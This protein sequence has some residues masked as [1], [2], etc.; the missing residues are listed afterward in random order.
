MGRGAFST[1]SVL[2][3]RALLPF[4]SPYHPN[5]FPLPSVSPRG[6][7]DASSTKEEKE[8]GSPAS[9]F[10]LPPPTTSWEG[11]RLWYSFSLWRCPFSP[12]RYTCRYL[13][14]PATITTTSTS[15]SSTTATSFS[16]PPARLSS[17]STSTSG[18][19]WSH[20]I[21]RNP[22][23]EKEE[24][25][26]NDQNE[27]ES[28]S[29]GVS[30]W[31]EYPE[32]DVPHRVATP[33]SSL[34]PLSTCAI[35]PHTPFHRSRRHPAS[36][37]GKRRESEEV[38]YAKKKGHRTS[39]SSSSSSFHR[40][41]YRHPRAWN[42]T[43]VEEEERTKIAPLRL[44]LGYGLQIGEEETNVL[45][46]NSIKNEYT[47]GGDKK[48][49]KRSVPEK[50]MEHRK[51]KEEVQPLP[52]EPPCSSSR[53]E[54]ISIEEEHHIPP[55]S[56]K[57]RPGFSSLGSSSSVL[58]SEIP[59]P[60]VEGTIP[61][62]QNGDAIE[63]KHA[64]SEEEETVSATS[65]SSTPV[66]T[67]EAAANQGKE[68]TAANTL[69]SNT[70][71]KMEHPAAAAVAAVEEEKEPS[72]GVSRG[73]KAHNGEDI[74][75][76]CSSFSLVPPSLP[77]HAL[78]L[79]PP[80]QNEIASIQEEQWFASTGVPLAVLQ[81]TFC[82][83]ETF[84]QDITALLLSAPDFSAPAAKDPKKD[85]KRGG[86]S[87]HENTQPQQVQAL[88]SKEGRAPWRGSPASSGAALTVV[89]QA[90]IDAW[91]QVGEVWSPLST[92]SSSS[93]SSARACSSR[94]VS[95]EVKEE[96]AFF[97]TKA[98]PPA[99]PFLRAACG[100]A[101][102]EHKKVDP[103]VP[104]G[105]SSS[106][107][108]SLARD[109][110][111][112]SSLSRAPPR[113][114]IALEQGWVP[115]TIWQPLATATRSVLSLL[116]H[117]S[118]R[119]EGHRY[120]SL[121]PP[122]LV[123][124][125]TSLLRTHLEAP[126]RLSPRAPHTMRSN[127]PGGTNGAEKRGTHVAGIVDPPEE[128]E[129]GVRSSSSLSAAR[130]PHALPPSVLVK[131]WRRA[132]GKRL[133]VLHDLLPPALL[134]WSIRQLQL[135][136]ETSGWGGCG[137]VVVEDDKDALRLFTETDASIV[138]AS[139]LSL[140]PLRAPSPPSFVESTMDLHSHEWRKQK[141]VVV[142]LSD[143]LL[144]PMVK[145]LLDPLYLQRHA[146]WGDHLL[147]ST[148]VHSWRMKGMSP[149][150][151]PPPPHEEAPPP[152]NNY[153]ALYCRPVRRGEGKGE[154][155]H[156]ASS[157]A[158]LHRYGYIT[159]SLLEDVAGHA[160]VSNS[161]ASRTTTTTS[162]KRNPTGATQEKEGRP[163][164]DRLATA[165]LPK[166]T[167]SEE[168]LERHR[169]DGTSAPLVA[170]SFALLSP[171]PESPPWWWWSSSSSSSSSVTWIHPLTACH[172]AAV[173]GRQAPPGHF[174]YHQCFHVLLLPLVSNVLQ[175]AALLV[176]QASLM[177]TIQEVE[178][179][180][181]DTRE[182]P[183]RPTVSSG[184]A[185]S[186]STAT[187]T[188]SVYSTVPTTQEESSLPSSTL[189]PSLISLFSTSLL[190]DLLRGC[191]RY[192]VTDSVTLHALQTLLLHFLLSRR[193][194]HLSTAMELLSVM[195]PP[196]SSTSPFTG[197]DA[198]RSST[199]PRRQS[200]ATHPSSTHLAASSSSSSSWWNGE[201]VA[202]F[203]P[204]RQCLC[205]RLAEW[206]AVQMASLLLLS[207][208]SSTPMSATRNGEEENALARGSQ[209]NEHRVSFS[210]PLLPNW[211]ST[212][213]GV[214]SVD[215]S[216]SSATASAAAA[217]SL[218][219]SMSWKTVMEVVLGLL[220]LWP[221][222]A[223]ASPASSSSSSVLEKEREGEA[224][225][226]ES[227]QTWEIGFHTSLTLL[228][229][230][231]VRQT[232]M[233][234]RK[235]EEEEEKEKDIHEE[236]KL[237][238]ETNS[239]TTAGCS[240]TWSTARGSV[241]ASFSSSSVRKS[242]GGSGHAAD[243]TTTTTTA[244]E[245]GVQ[246]SSPC[247]PPLLAME[248]FTI[249]D[250]TRLLQAL[251]ACTASR[252]FGSV[253]TVPLSP[254]PPYH[255]FFSFLLFE[256]LRVLVPSSSPPPAGAA[257]VDP[258]GYRKKREKEDTVTK[259]SEE[260]EEASEEFPM[261]IKEGLST[262]RTEND[263]TTSAPSS[264]PKR[265][266]KQPINPGVREC[267]RVLRTDP[268]VAGVVL[269]TALRM[270]EWWGV[271]KTPFS[272]SSFFSGGVSGFQKN[273]EHHTST[274]EEEEWYAE[275]IT[276]LF[277]YHET[278]LSPRA[279]VASLSLLGNLPV[280]HESSCGVS[281]ALLRFSALPS[282]A[283]GFRMASCRSVLAN[284]S[285]PPT[286]SRLSSLP[287]AVVSSF[288]SHL[289]R[290]AGVVPP[291]TL[292][293]AVVS[294]AKSQQAILK[295]AA[296]HV[297]AM[298]AT[299]TPFPS[300]EPWNGLHSVSGLSIS[301]LDT[302]SLHH[303][304]TRFHAKDVTA[305]LSLS[306][307]A[308]LL[309]A[310]GYL[311]GTSQEV[312]SV[313]HAA[314]WM[315]VSHEPRRGTKKKESLH[316]AGVDGANSTSALLTVPQK[317][318][319]E[320]VVN[321]SSSASAMTAWCGSLCSMATT[322]SA[323][324]RENALAIRAIVRRVGHLLRHV[325]QG[326]ELLARG[327][328]RLM[329]TP[330][331]SVSSTSFSSSLPAYT[332]KEEYGLSSWYRYRHEQQRWAHLLSTIPRLVTGLRWMDVFHAPLYARLC[333][334]LYVSVVATRPQDT[335]RGA[336][337][338]TAEEVLGAEEE[339]ASSATT[340]SSTIPLLPFSAILPTF[341]IIAKEWRVRRRA[342]SFTFSTRD[343]ARG[344]SS[345]D[346]DGSVFPDAWEALRERVCAL[347]W[348]VE[349]GVEWDLWQVSSSSSSAFSS[350]ETP[351]SVETELHAKHPMD[352]EK[353]A[354][355]ECTGQQPK[356]NVNKHHEKV[357]PAT[358]PASTTVELLTP[359]SPL[360]V[361]VS[362]WNAF[363]LLDVTDRPL[364]LVL[365]QRLWS[366]LEPQYIPPPFASTPA[367]WEWWNHAVAPKKR[368]EMENEIGARKLTDPCE[369][370]APLSPLDMSSTSLETGPSLVSSSSPS[371]S[372][373]SAILTQV[374]ASL[375]LTATATLVLTLLHRQQQRL[376]VHG[377]AWGAKMA[378]E[379]GGGLG[380]KT[381]RNEPEEE[382]AVIMALLPP[383][384]MAL[385]QRQR[386]ALAVS[387][388]LYATSPF[389]SA[390]TCSSSSSSLYT[391]LHLALQELDDEYGVD[392][393]TPL[394]AG[395]TSSSWSGS[396]SF[397]SSGFP[398]PLHSLDVTL[399]M[400]AFLTSFVQL[401]E[402]L[403]DAAAPP[404][405]PTLS[406]IL[407]SD[408]RVGEHEK[409]AAIEEKKKTFH[410]PSSATLFPSPRWV[411]S[412]FDAP[413]HVHLLHKAYDRLRESFLLYVDSL[414]DASG[415]S[416]S[417]VAEEKR[418]AKNQD[419]GTV[420]STPPSQE[421]SMETTK[422]APDSESSTTSTTTAAAERPPRRVSTIPR[423]Y[424]ADLLTALANASIEDPPLAIAA[425][426]LFFQGT[427]RS[428]STGFAFL[429]IDRL[430]HLFLAL[431]FH[432][433]PLT[434]GTTPAP[435]A[436][437]PP[438]SS[439]SSSSS[440]VVVSTS[441]LVAY[442]K[443]FLPPILDAIAARTEELSHSLLQAVRRCVLCG[444]GRRLPRRENAEQ[445]QEDRA[446]EEA[447]PHGRAV[448][449]QQR[450]Q[451]VETI[452]SGPSTTC[453][454]SPVVDP[455]TVEGALVQ[456]LDAQEERLRQREWALQKKKE[457]LQQK[458]REAEVN[459][460]QED[461]PEQKE[462]GL[463]D[464][465]GVPPPTE[466][467]EEPSTPSTHAPL[468]TFALDIPSEAAL[469][470]L[471]IDEWEVKTEKENDNEEEKTSTEA[472][473]PPPCPSAKAR[474]I[475][476]PTIAT[477]VSS[478]SCAS[479]SCA[480]NV[481]VKETSETKTDTPLPSPHPSDLFQLL[482]ED[483]L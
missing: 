170:S 119:G 411:S 66:K 369:R 358:S 164:V 180:D 213:G 362:L 428:S 374:F 264:P 54:K 353:K 73:W 394:H 74:S 393:S 471:D 333:R 228:L 371:S 132:L 260:E 227:A 94:L 418:K 103:T 281:S 339:E 149:L 205:Q 3:L 63:G 261:A 44:A 338:E 187:T 143:D 222:R 378:H 200:R 59:R 13:H 392:P 232:S 100:V 425:A 453:T 177:E 19:L 105:P 396:S 34:P 226:M 186:S 45:Q 266:Q 295:L 70:G 104:H 10:Y 113:V 316:A 360:G 464:L 218:T 291:P 184:D 173:L 334:L 270:Y 245:E 293:R 141:K 450:A 267:Q 60:A 31:L 116:Q 380:E 204:L 51:R 272:S 366:L 43:A 315:S 17:S 167:G 23:Q 347:Q 317:T 81:D 337:R 85:G 102:N 429:S 310:L 461:V 236:K 455:S 405:S 1:S 243:T 344:E 482:E 225:G 30:R 433:P 159:L 443:R 230:L 16:S 413:L 118:R 384:L 67:K 114:I 11:R 244:R 234:S 14:S 287:P 41:K 242:C 466:H 349:E 158:A 478:S 174:H 257:V 194:F 62:T 121:F 22:P 402:G 326:D 335:K 52:V 219:S 151:P 300:V 375:S 256:L 248:P 175:R 477:N 385:E 33:P 462:K 280:S 123:V 95:Q 111:A 179:H 251:L 128:E 268:H 131:Q 465:R 209:E 185:F 340:T 86:G 237:Q 383:A 476:V 203:S 28:S 367:S 247:A 348:E 140:A 313:C 24:A 441:S 40:S 314:S 273:T 136:A 329:P 387:S 363:S 75:H 183:F 196:S 208:S 407:P 415:A 61:S 406:P 321:S 106:L 122:A 5:R 398:T 192:S 36:D 189:P 91:E 231:L 215:P 233:M 262:T 235:G 27:K 146:Q 469:G 336:K 364:F 156:G 55:E 80:P 93:S 124:V 269:H 430:V 126:K 99:I 144:S 444:G 224:L 197:H 463:Q 110:P 435:T 285:S 457:A 351:H 307:C 258:N 49:K 89:Q 304:C 15:T 84:V 193:H 129:A 246:S 221:Y 214:T 198:P 420:S 250:A 120:V 412:C 417:G 475:V 135:P 312:L 171:S 4:S 29:T 53:R 147:P 308:S 388:Y 473:S 188:S 2:L 178:A 190:L 56:S 318:A 454:S 21:H 419:E 20:E 288:L 138:D 275:G 134:G 309:A 292:V 79:A 350:A 328:P 372:L 479:S 169:T 139:S 460:A 297:L 130:A 64:G 382:E 249:W 18:Y 442:R 436:I 265:K 115:Y 346:G 127:E 12:V 160:S 480:S 145:S 439:S 320:V 303:W 48:R 294:L 302:V 390:P 376:A 325:L 459:L 342:S 357:T 252:P 168:K 240:T 108:Y 355:L 212:G 289:T 32:R 370:E 161:N 343:S 446:A 97:F 98:L 483:H 71:L 148:S 395:V 96:V 352:E 408:T 6:P 109:G 181:A 323:I 9:F 241:F 345:R 38:R 440:S 356:E 426:T 112:T 438:S 410:H 401:E 468:S 373:F 354:V 259:T 474:E 400:I 50:E 451:D 379:N 83:V 437:S 397:V 35:D 78:G 284:I 65:T 278:A 154:A 92:A 68:E 365:L 117:A 403:I 305:T 166:G 271:G 409:T 216:S 421:K 298:S 153:M 223:V 359:S 481:P 133:V 456:Q 263:T 69:P 322:F 8:N 296:Q 77:P 286:I 155:S 424:L 46:R 195:R 37:N 101:I 191:M 467:A 42:R 330:M 82:E 445:K 391:R 448:E 431:C 72:T 449:S 404:V 282:A 361:V 210:P 201:V 47:R 472:I 39:P 399:L 229:D 324:P 458:A 389:S 162:A 211:R 432:F 422:E 76:S 165:L 58:P 157:A 87:G 25:Q 283:A 423:E 414:A 452:S 182:G 331:L 26:R 206:S 368:E 276:A 239:S 290:I 279:L 311:C 238:K 217:L 327:T 332:W 253:P 299:T 163:L 150:P 220:R 306:H 152:H 254:I 202:L 199:L 172:W 381:T 427:A 447:P 470:F 176:E 57:D 107:E 377:A 137:G 207:S 7:S 341:Q 301:V 386:E 255:P 88:A 274:Q 319:H 142:R 277:R 434:S 90:W 416:A 125:L